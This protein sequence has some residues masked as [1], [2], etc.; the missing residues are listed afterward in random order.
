MSGYKQIAKE[1]SMPNNLLMVRRENEYAL[2]LFN[3][4]GTML[5]ALYFITEKINIKIYIMYSRKFADKAGIFKVHLTEK[6]TE[7]KRY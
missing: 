1:C 5:G 2:G 7:T 3:V 6:G 4:P